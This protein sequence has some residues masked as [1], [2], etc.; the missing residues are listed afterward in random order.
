[1]ILGERKSVLDGSDK[2]F[3]AKALN[4][5]KR[6]DRQEVLLENASKSFCSASNYVIDESDAPG[7]SMDEE[8]CLPNKTHRKESI[9]LEF[10]KKIL[11]IEEITNAADRLKLSDSQL[12]AIVSAII[13]AGN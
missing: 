4:Q 13:K 9:Q 3:E 10:P 12:I 11:E 7:D 6:R 2:I 1:M 8:F 5:I